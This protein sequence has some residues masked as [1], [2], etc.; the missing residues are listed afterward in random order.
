MKWKWSTISLGD[1]ALQHGG[2]VD[3]QKHLDEEFELYS[4]PAFDKG[5]PEVATG[6]HIG[7]IKKVVQPSDVMISRIVP[8]IRRACIVGQNN[9]RRQIASGEWIIF[10][11]K[12][13]YP[14][15]LRWVVVGDAFHSA[16]MRTVSGVGGSLL[17]ARPKEVFKIEIPLP[18]LAEQK[19][20]AAIMDAADA[21]RAKRR[22]SLA[23]L[24]ILLQSTFLDVFGDPVT[25]PKG[26]EKSTVGKIAIK[27][28]DGDHH[29]PKRSESG[30]KLLSARN[31]L[32]GWVDLTNTDFVEQ[33]EYERMIKRCHPER[34]DILI[35]CSGSIGR[36]ARITFT[37]PVVLVRSAALIK[38]DQSVVNSIFLEHFLRT[39]QLQLKMVQSAKSSSQANLF[40]K[41]IRDLPTLLPPLTLQHQFAT[42]VESVEKQKSRLRAHLSELDTL[43]ASLQ[44]RAFNGEL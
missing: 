3:P 21:L 33:D 2:S 18:P 42:I 13:I 36:V 31:I 16:F 41:P 19:R 17:R 24:D 6:A 29:T 8:H 11:S 35:S 32:H 34:E 9:G 39:P 22:E 28:T 4:I 26:W 7:S 5:A 37:E 43:F 15:Y 23:Q 14:Q 1:I 27:V 40:Q 12:D 25:N 44:S 10:R 30:I 38:P 20:I